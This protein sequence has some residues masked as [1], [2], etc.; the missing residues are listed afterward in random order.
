[1]SVPLMFQLGFMGVALLLG[2][3]AV[4]VCTFLYRRI[5]AKIRAIETT[6]SAAIGDLDDGYWKTSGQAVALEELLDSPMKKTKCIFYHF[7]VEELRSRTETNTTNRGRGSSTRSHTTTYWE[8]VVTDR[9]AIRCAV[10]DE[11]GSAR[12]DLLGAETIL[13]TSAHSTSGT[14]NN[15]PEE[16]K[17]TLSRRYGLETKGLLFNKNLKYTETLIEEGDELFVIGDVLKSE[18]EAEFVRGTQPFIVSDRS[19]A[20]LVKEYHFRGKLLL[21]GAV[22]AGIIFSVV[23][24]LPFL[25]IKVPGPRHEEKPVAAAPSTPQKPLVKLDAP[26]VTAAATSGISSNPADSPTKS[27]V[28]IA[29]ASPTRIIA[30]TPDK[31]VKPQDSEPKRPSLPAAITK[32]FADLRSTD[33]ITRAAGAASLQKIKPDPVY[34]EEVVKALQA[35]TTDADVNARNFALKA[36]AAWETEG[37]T[38][39]QAVAEKPTAAS[40]K[41]SENRNTGEEGK[42]YR[43]ERKKELPWTASID[44]TSNTLS[45]PASPWPAFSLSGQPKRSIFPFLP[46]PFAVLFPKPA[47]GQKNVDGLMQVYDLRSGRATG[48]PFVLKLASGEHAALALDGSCLAGR[49][50]GKE[51]PHTIEVIDTA[52][53]QSIKR[54]EAGH[55][56]EWAHPV[57]FIGPDR[58]LTKTHEAQ[59]PDWSEKTEYKVWNVR[60]GELLSEF[61]FDLVGVPTWVGI[62]GGGKYIVFQIARTLLGYRLVTIEINTGKAV[63]DIFLL[64]TNE[65]Q[66]GSQGIVYSP[67]GKEFAMLWRVG[68]KELWGKVMV[69]DAANGK[70]LATHDLVDMAGVETDFQGGLDSIQW[71]P[72]GSGWLIFGT[73]LVDR[74]TGKELGRLDAKKF[75]YR[76]FVGPEQVTMFKGGPDPSVSIETI[77]VV[78]R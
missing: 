35:A 36:L 25:I 75:G 65:A 45:S 57:A 39:V 15:C 52:S 72:D 51:T 1:M 73:L 69:F 20:N 24:S 66:G 37:T 42:Y 47:K 11:T 68:K 26:P 33:A 29:E 5:R 30:P 6:P 46:S 56:K 7:K 77:K 55:G 61:A 23:A 40:A 76:R 21:A 19:E 43:P 17:R 71:I 9:Q 41:E 70:R 31:V 10:K 8:T 32:A 58:L 3:G 16:L 54:I 28:G 50:A 67:D 78:G 2:V 12:L 13:N 64:E 38:S 49:I 22:A 4:A 27:A 62:S 48:K 60:T 53:G 34:R 63:G 44:P 74:K 14:F 59:N 18:D